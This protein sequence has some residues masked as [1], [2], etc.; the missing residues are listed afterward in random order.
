MVERIA[1]IQDP[2]L[3][4]AEHHVSRLLVGAL[5][6]GYAATVYGRDRGGVDVI[7]QSGAS[8][9]AILFPPWRKPMR[10][11]TAW[12]RGMF[13]GDFPVRRVAGDKPTLV[14]SGDIWTIP[15][16]VRISR[17]LKIPGIGFVQAAG[18]PSDALRRYHVNQCHVLLV[19]SFF[20]RGWVCGLGVPPERVIVVRPGVDLLRFMPGLDGGPV[21]REFGIADDAFVVGCVGS[22]SEGKNQAFLLDV[23]KEMRPGSNVH[24][25]LI[26]S[27]ERPYA[28][29]LKERI[30]ADQCE[31]RFT[32]AGYR[33]DMPETLS[34]CNVLAMP[35]RWEAFPLALAEAFAMG[36]PVIHS[37]RGGGDE[38]VGDV[39]RAAQVTTKHP[40]LWA[41][42]LERV[43]SDARYRGDLKTAARAHAVATLDVHEGVR[44]FIQTLERASSGEFPEPISELV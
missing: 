33:N 6:E 4:G 31:D 44:A 26:G 12:C 21:R 36:L 34:A 17:R 39:S 7:R 3:G 38:V 15:Y 10:R 40:D 27:D 20:L 9:E 30:R 32:F 28:E 35:S 13:R 18:L 11:L 43:E 23:L 5:Q 29:A 37:G 42:F 8:F 41:G 2:G 24:F 16:A 25:L 22:V 14:L 19:P 1:V